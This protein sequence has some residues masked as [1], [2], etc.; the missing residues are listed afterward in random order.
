MKSLKKT[1]EGMTVFIWVNLSE[2]V[3]IDEVQHSQKSVQ[4]S[5]AFSDCSVNRTYYSI[6][7]SFILKCFL[8]K[9]NK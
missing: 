6:T 4:K 9:K 1:S 8:M 3:D 7:P 2:Q 5:F